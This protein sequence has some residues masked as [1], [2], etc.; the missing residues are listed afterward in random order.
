VLIL[1]EPTTGVDPLSRRQFWDILAGLK[2]GGASIVVSTPYMDEVARADRAVF[3]NRGKP[4]AEGAPRDLVRRYSGQVYEV[5]L[6]VTGTEMRR[7]KDTGIRAVRFGAVIHIHTHEMADR[8]S[9]VAA[10]G[11]AGLSPGPVRK[12]GPGLEDVFIQ[13]MGMEPGNESSRT[14]ETDG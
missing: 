5:P 3:M 4:L 2:A 12:I 13:L 10:L 14:E 1:D 11:R 6:A 7:L 9:V 8:D